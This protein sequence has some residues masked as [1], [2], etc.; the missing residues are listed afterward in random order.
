MISSEP[1]V[2]FGNRS[3][4]S[5]VEL[6]YYYWFSISGIRTVPVFRR[7]RRQYRGL[8]H[9]GDTSMAPTKSKSPKH[10]RIIDLLTAEDLTIRQAAERLGVSISSVHYASRK[11]KLKFLRAHNLNRIRELADPAWLARKVTVEGLTYQEIADLL[12]CSRQYVHQK[13]TEFGILRAGEDGP[14]DPTKLAGRPSL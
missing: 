1:C 5:A 12:D 7:F 4:L 9:T 2:I 14:A 11:Y 3:G 6:C 13:V 8:W 10:Q